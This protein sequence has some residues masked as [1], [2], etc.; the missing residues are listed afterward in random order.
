MGGFYSRGFEGFI[1]HG[2]IHASFAAGRWDLSAC[3]GTIASLYDTRFSS[4]PENLGYPQSFAAFARSGVSPVLVSI[5]AASPISVGVAILTGVMVRMPQMSSAQSTVIEASRGSRSDSHAARAANLS[6]WVH[7]EPSSAPRLT[8]RRTSSSGCRRNAC[9]ALSSKSASLVVK[10]SSSESLDAAAL[11]CVEERFAEEFSVGGV[12]Q[13]VRRQ[14]LRKGRKRS[15]RGEQKRAV[16]KFVVLLAKAGLR[17]TNGPIGKTFRFDAYKR[18][19]AAA[20]GWRDSF[21]AVIRLTELEREVLDEMRTLAQKNPRGVFF[22]RNR[23]QSGPARVGAKTNGGAP[24]ENA[25][26]A[27][28]ARRTYDED[29]R[30]ARTLRQRVASPGE[31]AD[32][33]FAYLG[34]ALALIVLEDLFELQSVSPVRRLKIVVLEF[35]IERTDKRYPIVM[36]FHFLQNRVL[37]CRRTVGALIRSGE[38]RRPTI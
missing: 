33:N 4:N 30:R 20:F 5:R 15:S 29:R 7:G 23:D 12:N 17:G 38:P 28:F 1:R 34:Q 31:S 3:R 25:T 37:A 14:D 22:K 8:R 35:A 26:G 9:D 32:F 21:R 10:V 19:E 27:T 36:R 11:A 13:R 6:S 2:L 18:N 16:P 24:H